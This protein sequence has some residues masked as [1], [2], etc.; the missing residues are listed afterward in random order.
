MT[1]SKLSL[2]CVY[3]TVIYGADLEAMA[4]F[5]RDALG[6]RLVEGPN[7]LVAVFRLP[8]R[9]VLLIFDPTIASQPG[10]PVPSHGATEPTH[11]AFAVAPGD[12]DHWRAAL[13]VRGV[14][15]EQEIT[16]GGDR[17][18]LYVRDPASNSVELVEGDLWSA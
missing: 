17:R 2:S 16:W 15:I 6:L 9:N 5:Y 12:L 13:T 10:R 7:E 11:I 4:A 8:D 18:S 14:P 3:E 1:D